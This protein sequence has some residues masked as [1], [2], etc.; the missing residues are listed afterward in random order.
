MDELLYIWSLGFAPSDTMRGI[1]VAL[2]LSLLVVKS[3]QVWRYALYALLADRLFPVLSNAVTGD[4][5]G[6]VW[7]SISYALGN[8]G[9][10]L[11]VMTIRFVV[12]YAI[13]N[14]AFSLRTTVHA[15][16]AK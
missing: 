2:L 4:S 7:E 13:I 10:D 8:L 11:G 12:M 14:F 5:L 6:S 1:M 16:L 3:E 15:R 9:S